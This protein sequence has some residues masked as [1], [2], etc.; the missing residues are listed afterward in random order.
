VS[1]KKWVAGGA[2]GLFC[3]VAIAVVLILSGGGETGA[4]GQDPPAS[5]AKVTLGKLSALVTL[6]GTLTYR[7]QADGSPYSVINQAGGIYTELPVPG[8]KVTCGED[9]YRVDDEPVLLLC[10]AIPAYRDLSIGLAGNDVRQLNRNLHRL[11]YDAG[12]GVEID[13]EADD[14]TWETQV[15]LEKLQAAKGLDETGTLTLDE[16]MFQPGPVRTAKVTGKPGGSARPG[17]Q[18]A[19][20]TS[21][22]LEVQVNLDASQQNA[23]QV[24][25]RARITLPGNRSVAGKVERF[26]RVARS[27]DEQSSLGATAIQA[28]IRLDDRSGASG[29]DSAPVQ[30]E[31]TTSGVKD[32]LSVPSEALVGKSGGGFAVEVVRGDD[33]R[34]EVAV[35]LGLFDPAN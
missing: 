18:V 27:D 8:E 20:A 10:G 6:D 26:G 9:L 25:D 19:L 3:L 33:R 34:E 15:A 11:G 32:A 30:A 29:L 35:K 4:N 28:F 12:A 22:R 24:G 16:A 31:I 1:R 5:T 17:E 23:M 7:A 13:P 14:F 2:A 21:D